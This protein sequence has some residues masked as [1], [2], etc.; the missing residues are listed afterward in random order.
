MDVLYFIAP[1]L[2][3][4]LLHGLLL[5]AVGLPCYSWYVPDSKVRYNPLTTYS[6]SAY[7]TRPGAPTPMPETTL[8]GSGS[9]SGGSGG[10]GSD[11]SGSGSGPDAS[12]NGDAGSDGGD[13]ANA[14]GGSSNKG[15]GAAG[16]AG[17]GQKAGDGSA[18]AADA[19]G[20]GSGGDQT[21]LHVGNGI[22]AG[23]TVNANV[24][25]QPKHLSQFFL[26]SKYVN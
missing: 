23:V 17:S 7:E 22:V 13:S 21:M 5:L 14:N 12:G 15:S 26:V 18:G 6:P 20:T 16:A 11:G 25:N 8:K 2:N 1:S 3:L 4:I 10:G 9:G 19:D 24:K